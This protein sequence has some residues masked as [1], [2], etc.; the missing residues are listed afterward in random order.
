MSGFLGQSRDREQEQR[1]ILNPDRL[2]AVLR[3]KMF[4][5]VL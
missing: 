5:I 3:D 4:G 1:Q 2:I